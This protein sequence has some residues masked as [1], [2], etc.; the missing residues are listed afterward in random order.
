ML[1]LLISEHYYG[2][3]YKFD[4]ASNPLHGKFNQFLTSPFLL[5]EEH[6]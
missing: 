3:Q 6:L 4:Q 2:K 1:R 5:H